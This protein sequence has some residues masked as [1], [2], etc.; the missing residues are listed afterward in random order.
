MRIL[1]SAVIMILNHKIKTKINKIL[2]E[3]FIKILSKIFNENH[4]TL[5]DH[6]NKIKIDQNSVFLSMNTIIIK[7]TIFVLNAVF[8]IIQLEAVNSL[9]T[10]IEHL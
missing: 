6:S 10:S 8:Q 3:T 4:M 7:K 5:N 2:T 9:L 1:I